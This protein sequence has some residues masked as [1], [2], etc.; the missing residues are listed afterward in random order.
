MTLEEDIDREAEA[1]RRHPK[2]TA[3]KWY[4]YLIAIFFV[5][6]V[7]GAIVHY[8]NEAGQVAYEQTSPK[9]ILIKYEWFKD[10]S[11]SL[12]AKLQTISAYDSKLA[13]ID[14]RYGNKSRDE[15]AQPDVTAYNTYE[16]ALMGQ[17]GLYNQDAATYN[18]NMAKINWYWA[19]VG[20]LPQGGTPVPREYRQYINTVE[21]LR[22]M[23]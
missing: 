4:F 8:A 18:A 23:G 10:H 22:I 12:D 9:A 13:Q 1:F 6:G 19:N 3:I 5:L 14:K 7:I 15:W 16:S 17:I 11:A 20:N 21:G 2:K